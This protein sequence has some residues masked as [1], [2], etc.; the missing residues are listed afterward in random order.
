MAVGE[1]NDAKLDRLPNAAAALE[2]GGGGWFAVGAGPVGRLG[3]YRQ[4]IKLAQRM[5]WVP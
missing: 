3:P 1:R 2:K 4:Y 5:Y